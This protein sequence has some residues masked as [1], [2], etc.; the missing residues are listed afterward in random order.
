MND[1]CEGG[2]GATAVVQQ[3]HAAVVVADVSG[4]SQ[5]LCSPGQEDV[6]DA[7]VLVPARRRRT[8]AV[9]VRYSD[10]SSGIDSEMQ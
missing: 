3:S 10:S 7:L 9:A 8:V 4:K 5:E 1:G 6:S 2:G